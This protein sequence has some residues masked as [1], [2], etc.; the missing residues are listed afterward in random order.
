M[1][2]FMRTHATSWIIKILLGLIIV[3]F[4]FWGVGRIESKKK[5]VVATVEDH[6]ITIGEF[7]RTYNNLLE[8][9]ARIF[10]DQLTPDIIKRMNI[11]QQA[12]DQL[13]N[14]FLLLRGAQQIGF[15]V[16]EEELREAILQYPAFQRE[17]QF[18]RVLY[19]R[20]LRRSG[21]EPRDF[22]E[23]IL[24]EL[25]I[26]RMTELIEDTAVVLPEEEIKEIYFLE[27]EKINLDFIKISPQAFKGKK[28][29]TEIELKGYYTEHEEEFRTPPKVKVLYL[30][31]SPDA[32]LHETTASPQEIQEFYDVNIE[33]YRNPKKVRV[34]HILIKVTSDDGPEEV[35]KAKKRA[36]KVL[37]EARRGVDFAA[38]ARKFS[39]GPSASKGGDLGYLSRGAL[40]P[41]LEREVFTLGKG[42]IGSLVRTDHGFHLIK[43]E[44]IQE[45]K[46]KALQ[47]VKDE[48]ISQIRKEK[49]TDLAAINAEDSAYKAK[50]KGDLKPFAE[51]AGLQVKE[52][53]PF[54]HG[55]PLKG[56]GPRQKF[57]SIAFTLDKGEISSAF[58]DREDFFVLQVIGKIPST[59]PPFEEVREKV[60]EALGSS[61]ANE[62]AKETAHNILEAWRK[63]EGFNE[64]LK[65]NGLKIE[66][67]GYFK[68]N[69]SSAP[70]IG[71][72]GK[73]AEDFATLTLGDPW[74]EEVAETEDAYFVI[75]LGEVK[76][77]NQAEYE[78][79]KKTYQE[80]IHGLSKGELLQRWLS[81]M[82]GKIEIEINQ[83]LLG[84]LR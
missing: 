27:N 37:E 43:V 2:K 15:Q 73:Y 77:V 39:D 48:I 24:R 40:L 80:T 67:T 5:T 62:L 59:I 20:A 81:A 29:V 75:K 45:E 57:S 64:L 30:K 21:L 17:G 55:E 28:N 60:K 41:V 49:A 26:R 54:S 1:L 44:D 84:S 79:E 46:V 22:E 23:M 47:E 83:E 78:K 51:E 12:L 25:T 63:G 13:I 11:K 3:V 52:L 10:G 14:A 74:P 56:L 31:I 34:R 16:R 70:R 53:G 42:E 35:A 18:D 66:K 36:E 50:K 68:R 58:Q 8:Y 19:L 9:Y 82:K 4:I 69:S 65:K 61:V 32:Y 76:T 7:D 71:V 38:L 6:F 72:L 33:R